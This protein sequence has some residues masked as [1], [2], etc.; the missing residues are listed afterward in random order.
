VRELPS[1]N[2]QK[3]V[4]QLIEADRHFAT[5][6]GRILDLYDLVWQGRALN[7]REFVISADEKSSIR[8]SQVKPV[9]A[10][11]LRWLLRLVVPP[12]SKVAVPVLKTNRLLR[13]LSFISAGRRP[14]RTESNMSIFVKA[15]TYL[16]AWDVHRAEVFGRC[17]TK[18]GIAPVDRLIQE[19]MSQRA[20]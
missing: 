16:A 9:T 1:I 13:G 12:G 10:S 4:R 2:T 11:N 20:L 15:W 7:A 17:D 18:S 19:V 3:T 14:Y 8:G 6:A 5:K